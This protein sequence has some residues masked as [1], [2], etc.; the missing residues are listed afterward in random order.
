[1][2]K[3]L[4]LSLAIL[5]LTHL[6]YGQTKELWGLFNSGGE[7][8]IGGI[9]SLDS[10]ANF[11]SIEYSFKPK[12]GRN[13][14]GYLLIA[15]NGKYY[16]TASNGGLQNN[17]T[18]FEFDPATNQHKIRFH[19]DNV[20]SGDSPEGP[21][22]Q[23]SNGLLYGTTKFGGI[24]NKGTIFS[25]DINTQVFQKIHD[26]NDFNG[27]QPRGG[28][29]QANSGKLYGLT[30]FGGPGNGNE[31]VLFEYDI[32][33]NT[34]A[35]KVNFFLVS[36]AHP[37]GNLLNAAD[38]NLYGTTYEGGAH[39]DGVLFKYE[40]DSSVYTVVSDFQSYTNGG[41]PDGNLI[42]A[43]D[44]NIYGVCHL[45][46]TQASSIDLGGT[47][48]R[49]DPS[50]TG[51][52]SYRNFLNLGFSDYTPYGKLVEHN[53]SLIGLYSRDG[54]NNTKNGNTQV[55]SYNLVTR[56]ISSRLDLG[57]KNFSSRLPGF[58]KNSNNKLLAILPRSGI[59]G[60]G[61]LL[62][63][64]P[65]SSYRILQNF[66]LREAS[67]PI[68]NLLEASNGLLYGTT[69]RGGKHNMG[70]LFSYNPS[71]KAFRILN[72]FS[73]SI[74]SGREPMGEL[75]E[76]SNG[77]ILGS[78][79]YGGNFDDGVIY[80]FNIN[81]D[82]ISI[83]FHFDSLSGR[84][85]RGGLM[86]ASNGLV[87]GTTYS[88]G[89]YDEGV[90]FEFDPNTNNYTKKRDFFWFD[91]ANPVG[92]PTEFRSGILYGTTS[93]RGQF[94]SSGTLYEYNLNTNSYT[95]KKQFEH[96]T[97][98]TG[99]VPLSTLYLAQDS[100]LYGSTSD[101]L[102]SSNIEGSLFN[103]DPINDSIR[104]ITFLKTNSSKPYDADYGYIQKSTG[105]LYTVARSSVGGIYQVSRLTSG[106]FTSAIPYRFTASSTNPRNPT[107]RLVSLDVC[108]HAQINNLIVSNLTICQG[109]TTPIQIQVS[110]S[111][112]LNDATH[113]VLYEDTCGGT[114]LQTNVTGSFALSP[115]SVTTT[116]FV[117]GE[118]GCITDA[119]CVDTTITV[120]PVYSEID[121][122]M[123]CSNSD[124]VFPDSVI[125][126][127]ITS[128]TNHLSLLSSQFQCDSSILT[129]IVI[130]PRAVY[131]TYDTVA[132]CFGDSVLLPD[133]S[134]YFNITDT[135]SHISK[136]VSNTSC[137]STINTFVEVIYPDTTIQFDTIC[138]NDFYIFPNN[139]SLQLVKDTLH[140]SYLQDP[141]TSC[142][143]IV[144]SALTVLMIDT[145]YNYDTVC[146]NST[147]FFPNSDSLNLN[148][149]TVHY[150]VLTNKNTGC[151]SIIVS[152]VKVGQN[153][154]DSVDIPK[155]YGD[156]I[157]FPDSSVQLALSNNIIQ[158]S[159][160]NSKTG[161]CDSTVVTL[162]NITRIDTTLTQNSNRI[163]SNQLGARY[164]WI[165]CTSGQPISQDTNRTLFAPYNSTFGVIISLNDCID[166]S[167]CANVISVKLN[168]N[169]RKNFKLYP[170]PFANRI[171]IEVEKDQIYNYSI[172]DIKGRLVKTFRSVSGKHII[173]TSNWKSGIYWFEIKND[174]NVFRNKIIKL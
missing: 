111:S 70:V 5:F 160:I 26:F 47:V 139:D 75:I 74:N 135:L 132:I 65:H 109:D 134:L 89:T 1:M 14:L 86:M 90:L 84:N 174:E 130:D 55:F 110:T 77:I 43:S 128:D 23:A 137:D 9:Y 25:Y 87:Y 31:G 98:N 15:N 20:I 163:T 6:S 121:T 40:P 157:I 142:D 7:H 28:L 88:G 171:T 131:T 58:I 32:S 122:V 115:D 114:P 156:S 129:Q 103:Y 80:T 60:G 141:N 19:F 117:R 120:N 17:G 59:T 124:Y 29:T 112:Q 53:G 61:E 104:T 37:Q 169:S 82:S 154:L 22:I 3:L 108:R 136:L 149:D 159:I 153:L 49:F 67:F 95:V 8:G 79:R 148:N 57:R 52:L 27:A 30:E 125:F 166:T 127:N 91:G 116:Y 48:F 143:S 97:G 36:G 96:N 93:N 100:T 102:A 56:S 145:T 51:G 147:Y 85:P 10:N 133:S 172:F 63:Y 106:L 164:Q 4:I 45:K 44:G 13:P 92:L 54:P 34:Y 50:S 126:N 42:Q 46:N 64:T 12:T 38:S 151:D 173:E 18:I 170:N 167:E 39:R 81:R 118:G 119:A 123:V 105:E 16:G 113:W 71:T 107:G 33:T 11:N 161:N 2:K 41:H 76:Y 66:N 168:E 73:N 94:T 21:L 62:E 138:F 162:V 68:S 165:D 155:C 152:N 99:G 78:C 24:Y 140:Y 72:E 144:I 101:Y 150:S 69:I 158:T 35:I 83:A 146:Y